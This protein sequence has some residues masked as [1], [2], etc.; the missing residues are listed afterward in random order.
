[1]RLGVEAARRPT[2][3]EQTA[4]ASVSRYKQ[5]SRLS[6]ALQECSTRAATLSLYERGSTDF[7]VYSFPHSS[8]SIL[9]LRPYL[10]RSLRTHVS[11]QAVDH[12]LSIRRDT[13]CSCR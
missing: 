6:Y 3:A 11:R 7:G 4:M 5:S 2:T 8:T 12:G 9:N 13:R 1:M 10:A